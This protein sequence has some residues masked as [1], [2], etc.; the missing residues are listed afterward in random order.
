M[1][2]PGDSNVDSDGHLLKNRE[3]RTAAQVASILRT[4]LICNGVERMSHIQAPREGTWASGGSK[5]WYNKFWT[6]DAQAGQG[7]ENSLEML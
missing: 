2:G 5:R 6:N 3:K 1:T 4:S 7:T